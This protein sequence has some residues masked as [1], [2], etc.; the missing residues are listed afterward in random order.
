MP[1]KKPLTVEELDQ[2]KKTV[3]RLPKKD[4]V[5][6]AR[7]RLDVVYPPQTKK[8]QLVDHFRHTIDLIRNQLVVKSASSDA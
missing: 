3:N 1:Q 7:E 2:L 4:I 6:A 8:P 5:Q